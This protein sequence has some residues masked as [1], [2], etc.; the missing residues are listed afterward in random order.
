MRE[1]SG[2]SISNCLDDVLPSFRSWFLG[3]VPRDDGR[4]RCASATPRNAAMR[5]AAAWLLPRPSAVDRLQIYLIHLCIARSRA[6]RSVYYLSYLSIWQ[7]ADPR[8]TSCS[9]KD[10]SPSNEAPSSQGLFRPHFALRLRSDS[11]VL[12]V[13]YDSFKNKLAF[14]IMTF[15]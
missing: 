12:R 9:L 11:H 13:F 5:D 4:R 2:Q 3:H 15:L 6:Q 7:V 14:M 10:S 8:W 1:R